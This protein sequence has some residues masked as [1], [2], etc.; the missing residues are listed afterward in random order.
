MVAMVACWAVG[1]VARLVGL[2]ALLHRG[3]RRDP[4]AWLLAGVTAG[5]VA[6]AFTISHVS[7]GQAHFFH[8]AIPA[9]AVLATWLLVAVS[10]QPRPAWWAL[11]GIVTGAVVS[12]AIATWAPS[13]PEPSWKD[14][15]VYALMTLAGVVAAGTV[16]WFVTRSRAPALRGRGLAFVLAVLLGL[17]AYTALDIRRD[18]ANIRSGALPFATGTADAWHLSVAEM[19][20]AAWVAEHSDSGDVVATNVHCYFP[21]EPG[22]C[23]NR[24]FWVSGLTERRVVLEGWAYQEATMAQHGRDGLPFY[25]QTEPPDA[26]RL[27]VNDRVFTDPTP[28]AVAELRDTY[29]VRW[30]FADERAGEVSPRLD[31][32]AILRHTDGP[33]RI[34]EVPP[35]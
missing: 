32:V 1:Q 21:I 29:G 26:A 17:G 23:H 9:A 34:Y 15:A 18:V 5:G 6:A 27:A 13:L 8:S 19:R 7:N 3:I 24:T 35:G 33:V 4:A 2:G 30:L 28:T 25:Y 20:A 31:D 10:P 14:M 16:L 12:W 22:K 11:G